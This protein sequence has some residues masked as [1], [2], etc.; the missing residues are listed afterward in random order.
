MTDAA[1]RSVPAPADAVP[2]RQAMLDAAL[3]VFSR[4]GYRKASMDE[5]AQ[6]AGFSRQGLYF[7]Y[8]TKQDLFRATVLHSYTTRL[9]AVKAA[10]TTKRKSF[11]ARL[12]AALDEWV[13]RYVGSLGPN[14]SELVEAS[15][16]LASPVMKGYEAR[17]EKLLAGFLS[18]EPALMAA[19][20]AIGVSPI[21]LAQSVNATARGFKD[22]SETRRDFVVQVKTAVRMLC[23]PMDPRVASE[24][25]K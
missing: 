7:Y 3:G 13:G 16:L 15:G 21:Q 10:L 1:K 9:D 17:F 23:L 5:V 12:V 8:K 4:F 22:R 20:R 19:Y 11:P 25:K 6:A 18:R 24:I 2:R 14:A